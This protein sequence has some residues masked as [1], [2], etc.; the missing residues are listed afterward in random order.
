MHIRIKTKI[1]NGLNLDKSICFDFEKNTKAY[2]YLF[3]S[4]IDLIYEFFNIES[5]AN[6]NTL[7]KSIKLKSQSY[8]HPY[9]CSGEKKKNYRNSDKSDAGSGCTMGSVALPANE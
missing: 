6:N 3:S 9:I 1:E 8:I 5:R 7:S 2:N 4:G